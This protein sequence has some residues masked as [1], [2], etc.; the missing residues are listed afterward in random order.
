MNKSDKPVRIIVNHVYHNPPNPNEG[1]GAPL[2]FG[3][4]IFIISVLGVFATPIEVWNFIALG[5]AILL[6]KWLYGQL[7]T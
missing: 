7:F 1:S 6:G 2:F 4:I 5:V 3:I